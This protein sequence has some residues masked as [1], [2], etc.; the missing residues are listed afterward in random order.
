MS[1][2]SRNGEHQQPL[3][4]NIAAVAGL[5]LF[6]TAGFLTL[7]HL[8]DRGKPEDDRISALAPPPIERESEPVLQLVRPGQRPHGCRAF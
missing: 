8:S 7:R 5:L 2:H 1:Q 6:L 4:L 3:W